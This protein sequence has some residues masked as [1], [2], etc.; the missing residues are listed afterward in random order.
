MRKLILAVNASL[1]GFMGGVHGDMTWMV[2]DEEMD[3]DFTAA[4]R[5]RADTMLAGRATYQSFEGA[6]PAMARSSSL[7]PELT[8]F[9][10][11]MLT[12]P[13][14]VFS[15]GE[16]DLAMSNA[17]LATLPLAEEV[18]KLRDQPGRDLV[19]FGGAT[20]VGELVRLGLVDEYWLK[21]EPV[22]IGQGLSIF[23]RLDAP[24][25]LTLAWSKVYPSGVVGLRYETARSGEIVRSRW[26]QEE[27]V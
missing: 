4:I 11:W 14:V 8:V 18:A 27:K 26:V 3:H 12:T 15:H 22:A 5:D 16:P 6:W 24:V 23:G 19:V 7:S 1:D 2:E 21:V 20:I 9:A 13:I 10:E 17:R 25:D